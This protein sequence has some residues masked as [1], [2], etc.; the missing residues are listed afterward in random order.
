M[1]KKLILTLLIS[2]V[3]IAPVAAAGHHRASAVGGLSASGEYIYDASTLSGGQ[4]TAVNNVDVLDYSAYTGDTGT[5]ARQGSGEDAYIEFSLTGG[6]NAI[7]ITVYEPDNNGVRPDDLYKPSFQYEEF[8]AARNSVIEVDYVP[9]FG[10]V[11]RVVSQGTAGQW[12][13][14][15]RTIVMHST[16]QK[17]RVMMEDNFFRNDEVLLGQVRLFVY[18]EEVYSNQI[19]DNCTALS[20]NTQLI[21]YDKVADIQ[22]TDVGF[23]VKKRFNGMK[24]G[25][26]YLEYSMDG[27]DLMAVEVWEKINLHQHIPELDNRMY[28][29]Y[30]DSSASA[31]VRADESMV[32]TLYVK[33]DSNTLTQGG[34]WSRLLYTVSVPAVAQSIRIN[35]T[36]NGIEPD[37]QD[38]SYW[39]QQVNKVVRATASQSLSAYKLELIN[40]LNSYIAAKG[41]F[42]GD[43]LTAKDNTVNTVVAAIKNAL[44]FEAADAALE[45][46]KA[47][48]D[49]LTVDGQQ[50]KPSE[51]DY[52]WV[53]VLAC[54]GG[55]VVVAAIIVTVVLIRKKGK[56]GQK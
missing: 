3:I 46:G 56:T 7:E 51:K 49:K 14:Y 44:S 18:S 52:T 22:D 16:A 35:F 2:A 37:S 26:G 55:V 1:M 6:Q 19:V 24:G 4:I 28:F 5:L 15:T 13:K 20:G 42:T 31:Y 23:G 47:E 21:A 53:I 40:T 12:T 32:E 54:V 45:S 29:E 48:A 8:N 9:D 25:G 39:M 30:Y 50:P 36:D 11:E 10:I 34:R 33:G 38:E 17:V 43:N 41:S 27:Y